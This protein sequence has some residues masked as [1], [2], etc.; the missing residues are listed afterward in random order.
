MITI[1]IPC[2]NERD[3]IGAV[4][5]ALHAQQWP[6]EWEA[7]IADGMSDD[8]TREIL[9]QASRR[10][11]RIRVVDNPSR[12][13]STGLNLAIGQ[14][15]GEIVLRMDAHT[16]Y[17]TDYAARCL[18]ALD[19][20]GADNAG[21]PARTRAE[22]FVQRAVAA[23]YHSRFSTGGAHFHDD[24]YEGFVDTVPYGCWRKSTLERIGM[25]DETLVRNQDDELNLRL[26]RSGGRIWQSPAIVSWYRPRK[27]L[28]ALFRQ[29]FQYGFWKVEVIRKHRLPASWR[30]LVPGAFVLSN[31]LL[32]AGAAAGVL[33]GGTDLASF[34]VRSWAASA[35]LYAAV[36]MMAAIPAARKHGWDLLAIL[37]LVFAI[38]HTSYGLGFLANFLRPSPGRSGAGQQTR[39]A[40]TSVTR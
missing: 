17:A 9:D 25:F 8:G 15:R 37:P 19:R 26:V 24:R 35:A 13:V 14:A 23:A 33:A 5:D 22:G 12:F 3:H 34:F 20:S 18:E 40:F 16:E 39:S 36:C 10:D 30:H 32:V 29:Y 11:P 21:G 1:V 6:A 31:T 4:L 7:V 38:Y 27:S 2:R 28:W